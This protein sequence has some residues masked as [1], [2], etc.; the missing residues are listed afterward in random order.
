[1]TAFTTL[2]RLIAILAFGTIILDGLQSAM[3]EPDKPRRSI[4]RDHRG[5]GGAPSG[6]IT[7][8]GRKVEVKPPKN[9]WGDRPCPGSGQRREPKNAVV[10]DHRPKVCFEGVLGARACSR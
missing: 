1:M 2:I 3:A 9:C 6:G 4:V 10:R 8:N 7:V 5:P